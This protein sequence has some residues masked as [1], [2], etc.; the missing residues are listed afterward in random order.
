MRRLV[1]VL[2][3]IALGLAGGMALAAWYFAPKPRALPDGPAVITQM[4]EVARLETLELEVYKKLSFAPDPPQPSDSTWQNVVSWARYNL[5][6]PH[7]RAILFAK[8]HLGLDL[9]KIDADHVRVERDRVLLVLPPVTS[10]VE[11]EPGQTEIIDSNLDSAETARLL[12]EAK[13]AFA[14]DVQADARLRERARASGER[15]LRGLLLSLGFREVQV[16][17]SLPPRHGA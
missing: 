13:S 2:V 6:D 15:A 1:L 10:E 3:G 12:E 9:Q 14:R 5:R 8:V 16:V 4:R 17:E 7:G 11:L